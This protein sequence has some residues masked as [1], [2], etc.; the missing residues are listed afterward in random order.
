M[1]ITQSSTGFRPS[2][3]LMKFK[4]NTK[5]QTFDL[6]QATSV[7][8]HELDS[9]SFKRVVTQNAQQYGST[10]QEVDP[11]WR[12]REFWNAVVVKPKTQNVS[13]IMNEPSEQALN[14]KVKSFCAADTCEV[15]VKIQNGC[16][17]VAQSSER[18][19]A[20]QA[21]ANALNLCT[22]S[23][24]NMCRIVESL[25]GCSVGSSF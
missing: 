4:Y 20:A 6:T 18:Y 13:S 2:S 23:G 14:E 3:L 16:V 1:S 24:G 25:S 22:Q 5:S 12:K 21:K 7:R 15:L 11:K 10:L 8:Y 17:A 9:G 19:F